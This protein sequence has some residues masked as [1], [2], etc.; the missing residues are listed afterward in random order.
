MAVTLDAGPNV[1]ALCRKVDQ[2]GWA[3]AMAGLLAEVPEVSS[4]RV[5]ED[6]AGPGGLSVDA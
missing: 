6:L 5:I 2:P 4:L 1:H 3:D